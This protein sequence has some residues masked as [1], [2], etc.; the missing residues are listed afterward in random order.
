MGV[1]LIPQIWA[2]WHTAVPEG[3]CFDS[4]HDPFHIKSNHAKFQLN[5]W[6]MAEIQALNGILH[7]CRVTVFDS[8]LDTFDLESNNAKFQLNPIKNG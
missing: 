1:P 5:P 8:T 4:T 6:R 3:Y 7:Y 2:A